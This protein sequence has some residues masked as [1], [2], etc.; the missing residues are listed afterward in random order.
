MSELSINVWTRIFQ[1]LFL[2]AACVS[3]ISF[4][5][6]VLFQRLPQLSMEA[7]GLGGLYFPLSRSEI[8]HRIYEDTSPPSS[9][10]LSDT[11]SI[12]ASEVTTT[13][14]FPYEVKT[15]YGPKPIYS[16]D[17]VLSDSDLSSFTSSFTALDAPVY[18]VKGFFG[19]YIDVLS[20]FVQILTQITLECEKRYLNFFWNEYIKILEIFDCSYHAVKQS[21]KVKQ[22]LEKHFGSVAATCNILLSAIIMGIF[23]RILSFSSNWRF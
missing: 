14:F 22:C 19:T 7:L 10:I 15:L 21:S 20:T 6:N 3:D 17:S 11:S 18:E 12:K 5:K 2:I 1:N 16:T 9:E 23:I 8:L 13:S 4:Y